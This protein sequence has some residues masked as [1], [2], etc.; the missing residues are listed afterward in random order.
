MSNEKKKLPL[1]TF[2]SSKAFERWL[3]INHTLSAGVWL[4]FYKKD[5]GK[6]AFHYAEALDIALCYGWIDSQIKTHDKDSYVEKFTPRSRKSLWSK[7]N[8]EH[9]TRLMKEGKMA[10][11]GLREVAAAKK[12]GR[13]DS[14]YDSSKNMQVP[15]DFIKLLSKNKKAES[16]FNTLNKANIYAIAWRLQTAK[17]P[18]TREAR[19][20]KI[21]E[22][23]T[24]GKKFH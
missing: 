19:I 4:R 12:D 9:A 21:L 20:E 18:K 14:A 10:P 11:A 5:S 17:R 7:R 6:Y 3:K 23:L 1:L 2:V 8:R 22:M 24:K 15:D 16:F 13:W